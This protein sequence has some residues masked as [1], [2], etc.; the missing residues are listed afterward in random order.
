G[1]ILFLLPRL[2][3]GACTSVEPAKVEYVPASRDISINVVLDGKPVRGALVQLAVSGA[4]HVS[5]VST[6]QGGEAR[7]R[8]V[9]PGRYSLVAMAAGASRVQMFVEVLP[10][11]TK[12]T[13]LAIKLASM[14]VPWNATD[15]QTPREV[16]ELSGT[17]LDPSG[18]GIPFATIDVWE[19]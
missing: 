2:A 9:E 10:R 19:R 4:I 18:A 3:V 16:R 15:G 5:L 12:T 13:A 7:F 6:D 17:V 14:P 1:G 8:N 11:E